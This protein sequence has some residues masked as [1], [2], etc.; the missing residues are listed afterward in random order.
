MLITVFEFAFQTINTFNNAS[1]SVTRRD[2]GVGWSGEVV[3]LG[4]I[5]T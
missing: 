3:E 2:L 4:Q 5:T 1:L